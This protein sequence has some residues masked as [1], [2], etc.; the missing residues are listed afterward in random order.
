MKYY[1][2][3]YNPLDIIIY[4]LGTIYKVPQYKINLKF[5]KVV[6]APFLPITKA[7]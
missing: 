7:P 3:I 4:S 1:W 2:L 6:K 5:C